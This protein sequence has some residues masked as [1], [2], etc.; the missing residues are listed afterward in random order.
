MIKIERNPKCNNNIG[1]QNRGKKVHDSIFKE[2]LEN[3]EEFK[4]FIEDFTVYKIDQDVLEL[5]NKEFRTR[6]GL[7]IK[8]LDILYKIKDEETFIIIEHQSTV[9]YIMSE[10]MSDYCLALI[11]SR[12]KYMKK[13]KNRVAPVI[14][15][16][17]LNTAPKKWDATR[18]IKQDENNRCKFPTLK[19]PE[20][21]VID[22][23][24][25]TIDELLEKRTGIA[26][27]M[28]F[29]KIRSKK[30]ID[31]LIDKLKKRRKI[32]EREKM[33][34]RLIIENIEQ[35]IPKLMKKLREE[36]IERVKK[37]MKE[38]IEREGN[39]M[40]NFEKAIAK[41]IKENDKAREE[42]KQEGISIGRQERI[43]EVVKEMIKKKM[44][45]ED[46]IECT[47]IS[48]RELEELKLQKLKI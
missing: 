19:Y 44:K 13:S 8:Y 30:E 21:N 17:V 39:F 25:Y 4:D 31:S 9:D 5:Q 3:K 45:E 43:R 37:K 16:S 15:P 36:E 34:M 11:A 22:I 1:N 40:S 20:Y 33:G 32:N 24:D 38:I 6:L 41:I 23:N 18:T 12:K 29:E 27:A 7:R 10:R 42:G 14:L 26:V 28:A 48:K 47:K 46:I 2:L 35:I